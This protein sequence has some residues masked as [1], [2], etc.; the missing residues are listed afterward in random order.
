MKHYASCERARSRT[1]QCQMC[2]GTEHG[3]TGSIELAKASDP[4][5]RQELRGAADKAWHASTADKSRPSQR[6][7]Y[8]QKAAAIDSTVAEIIDFLA[9]EYAE[10]PPRTHRAAELVSDNSSDIRT[11]GNTVIDNNHPELS[12]QIHSEPHQ[13]E[14]RQ[15]EGWGGPPEATAGR[16]GQGAG[17]DSGTGEISRSSSEYGTVEKIEQLGNA[18]T[19]V[20]LKDIERAHQ[21]PVPESTKVALAD[22]FWCDLLAQIAHVID[23]GLTLF[24]NLPDRATALILASREEDRRLPLEEFV[25]K[26]AVKSVWTLIK[27]LTPLGWINGFRKA[28]PIIRILAVLICK[29]PERHEAVVRYCVDPLTTLLTNEV[30]KRLVKTLSD[31][32]PRLVGEPG[33]AAA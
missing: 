11:A 29:S 18:L 23:E 6:A 16:R 9:Q 12:R 19:D 27:S 15:A 21:G 13:A 33:L 22:H 20:A 14:T 32:L 30:K 5:A 8:P 7:T 1:C 3:W 4:R 31:W 28:L 26:V 25:V 24:D 2:C 17:D 10:K